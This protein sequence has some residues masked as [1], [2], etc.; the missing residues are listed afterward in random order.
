MNGLHDPEPVLVVELFPDLL[1]ELLNQLSNLS[2]EEWLLPTACQGWCVKDVAIHLLGDE[3]GNLSGRRDG[4]H[5]GASIS[6]WNELVSFINAWNQNW[7]QVGRRISSPL[8]IDMLRQTGR[9]LNEYFRELDPYMLGNSVSWAG[10]QPAPVWL[11]LAREY[12]ERWHHQQHI[13]D[14]VGKPGLKEQPYLAP[15]LA[16]FVWGFPWAFHSTYAADGTAITLVISGNSGGK[17][18]IVREGN[19]WRLYEGA[20]D[21]P[22]ARVTM[23]EELAWRLFTRGITPEEAR[24]QVIIEGEEYLGERVLE[25]VS[26]IA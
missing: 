1:N 22:N 6:D 19:G 7:V 23:E 17:W 15:V 10:P 8:L 11:D 9:Q 18:S 26:I 13:R 5:S 20:G 12:T 24:K 14:A 3:I 16:T 2:E 25:V 21:Q 4:Y